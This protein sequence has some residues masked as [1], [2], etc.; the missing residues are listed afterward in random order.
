MIYMGGAVVVLA[1]YL[2]VR[3]RRPPDEHGSPTAPHPCRY[4]GQPIPVGETRCPACGFK[5][6]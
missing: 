5:D 3:H 1:V 2:S 4:C 6:V